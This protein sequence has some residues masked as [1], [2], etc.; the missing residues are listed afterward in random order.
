MTEDTS[1][2]EAGATKAAGKESREGDKAAAGNSKSGS[3]P[4]SG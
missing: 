3:Q 4:G 2:H 1:L